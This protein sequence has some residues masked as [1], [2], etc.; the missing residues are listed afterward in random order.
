M[1]RIRE[2]ADWAQIQQTE[3]GGLYD[4]CVRAMD[5]VCCLDYWL[6]ETRDIESNFSVRNYE[7]N[8]LE[9]LQAACHAT[10]YPSCSNYQ[11][12][13][14]RFGPRLFQTYLHQL[15]IT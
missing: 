9:S 10:V 5:R 7:S 14:F 8:A 12:R 3:P 2:S 6:N 15:L 4:R 11:M 1:D 13:T